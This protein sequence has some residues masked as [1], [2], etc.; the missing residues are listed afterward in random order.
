MFELF[1][2]AHGAYLPKELADFRTFLELI[3]REGT[4]PA[5][6]D[7][8]ARLIENILPAKPEL[9][10]VLNISRAATSIVLCT[11]YITG[12]A[13]LASNHW[14]VFEYWV[15]AG[16]YILHLVEKSKR[17]E[18]ECDSSFEICELAA[19]SALFAIAEDCKER[20]DLVQGLPLVDSHVYRARVT[21]LIGLLCALDLSLRIRRRPRNYS[22]FAKSFLDERLKQSLCWGESAIPYYFLAALF[23]EQTCDSS[24]AESLAIRL[25]SD[26]SGANGESAQGRGAPNPYYSPE[27]SLRLSYGLDPLNEET[28]IRLSYSIAPLID[29]LAR[30][31]RRRALASLWFGVTRISLVDYVP[32]NAAEWFRWKSSGGFLNSRFAGEPQS[33]EALRNGARD[34]SLEN[35]PPTLLR[36]PAFAIW[37]LLVY[38]HRFTPAT[39]KLIDGAVLASKG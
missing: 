6:K 3:L 38:P 36:R 8:A 15:L 24:L 4:A 20:S 9:A 5:E 26:I 18:I 27:E 11:A 30:R 19:E 2:N 29:F 22:D 37:Y 31:W 16:A 34:L 33:W 14:C 28:F 12:P 7:K 35:L 1:R 10:S 25:I 32:A 13:A 21:I 39:A 17:A 23:A